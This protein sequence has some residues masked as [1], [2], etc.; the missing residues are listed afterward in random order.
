MHRS[1][2]RPFRLAVVLAA[3][4]ALALTACGDDDGGGGGSTEAFCDELESFAAG[5]GDPEDPTFIADF[6]ALADTA[7]S[8]ISTEM[9]QMLEV[10]EAIEELPDEPASEEEMTEMLE[11]AESIEEPI[12]AVEEFATE[13]CPDLPAS[14]FGG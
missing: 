6:R 9:D 7:P 11:L 13:N 4:A 2:A 14:V 10:F 1:T 8:D 3:G 12:A 5:T